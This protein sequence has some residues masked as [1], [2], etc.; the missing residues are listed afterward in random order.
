MAK[1]QT[2]NYRAATRPVKWVVQNHPRTQVNNWVYHTN[3]MMKLISFATQF[4][5]HIWTGHGWTMLWFFTTTWNVHPCLH[6]AIVSL[7]KPMKDT[8][9]T[10]PRTKHY[11]E[12]INTLVYLVFSRFSVHSPSLSETPHI[13]NTIFWWNMWISKSNH[14]TLVNTKTIGKWMF[15]PPTY[16]NIVV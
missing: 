5:K 4:C 6:V 8:L 12:H 9:I 13:K 2:T 1:K 10:L 3:D 7:A 16:W 11:I 14:G 15:I